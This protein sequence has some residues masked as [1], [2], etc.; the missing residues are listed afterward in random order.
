MNASDLHRIDEVALRDV[1]SHEERD[2][3]PWLEDHADRLAATIGI[4]ID[5]IHREAAVGDYSADLV[6]TELTTDAPVVIENQFGPTDHDHLGKLLTYA[7][8]I[9]ARFVVWVAEE[10]RDEH[11]SVLDWLNERDSRGP[12]FFGVRPRVIRVDGAENEVYGFEFTLVVEPNDW[13]QDLREPLSDREQAYQAFFA[14]LIDTY[15]DQHP[16]WNPPTPGSRSYLTFGAGLSGLEFAWVFHDES[17]FAVE[18]YIDTGEA[19]RNEEIFDALNE[20]QATIEDNLEDDVVW[21]RLSERRACRIKVPQPNS[22]PVE[23]LSLQGRSELI[24]WGIERMDAFRTVIE[25]SLEQ[26]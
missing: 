10:F 11:R 7:A 8:G 22:G 2:F 26:L 9:N 16:N 18:L 4:E 1:W 14:Q 6:G 25:P 15:A 17:E 23:E 24:N 19:E 3:T 20:E 5:E 12:R 13:E 21:E